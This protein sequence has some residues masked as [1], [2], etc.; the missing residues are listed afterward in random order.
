M[1]LVSLGLQVPF[2]PLQKVDLR[3]VVVVVE[4]ASVRD[5]PEDTTRIALTKNHIC[6][7]NAGTLY[8]YCQSRFCAHRTRIGMK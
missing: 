8:T 6:A 4:I 1:Y 2:P 5:V 7:M 3:W